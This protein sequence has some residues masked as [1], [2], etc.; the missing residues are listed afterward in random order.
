MMKTRN[1]WIRLSALLAFLIFLSACTRDPKVLAARYVEN[2]NKFFAREKYKEASIMYRRAL[3]KDLR[4]GEAYYRLGLTDEK[5]GAYGDAARMFQR[6]IE[7]QPNN[8]D[9]MTKLADIYLIAGVQGTG[10]NRDSLLKDAKDLADKLITQNQKSFDGHRILG[11]LALVRKDVPAALEEFR[12]ANQIQPDQPDV[13]ISYFRAL[14]LNK[15]FPEAEKLALDFLQ[16]NKSSASM[17]DVLYLEYVTQ[18]PPRIADAEKLLREKVEN[19]PKN[20]QYLIQLAT[21]YFVAKDRARM[22]EVMK[23]LTDEKQFPEGHLLGGDYYMFRIREFDNA[24]KEYL[25]GEKAFP[26]E[27]A[28]Y[29]KRRVELLATTAKNREANELLAQVIKDNPKDSDAIAMRAALMLSTGNRDQ[30]NQAVNDFQ[31]LV[32]KNPDN[33]LLRFNLGRALAAHGDTDAAILQLEEAAKLRPDFIPARQLLARLYLT[34]GDS[35]A[36]KTSED[37]LK[38][39][40]ADLTAHLVHANALLN[41]GEN[42]KASAELDAVNKAY[43]QSPEARYMLGYVAYA[44]KDY[45]K[46]EETFTQ[47]HKEN[48]KDIRG[49]VAVVRTLAAQHRLPDALKEMDEAYKAE[50]DRRDIKT[51]YANLLLSAEKYDDAIKLSQ[52]LV[53]KDPK[54][55]DLLFLMGEAYRRKG[56]L[57]S[58]IDY[59]RRSSVAAPND[60]AP[61]IQLALL[62]EGTGKRDQAKPIYEQILKLRPDQAIA[63]NNLAFIKAEEGTDLDQA[64]TMAQKALQQAPTSTDVADTLGWIYIKKN[65]SDEA[66]RLYKDLIN[67]DPNNAL[68][69]YHFAMALIQKGDRSQAKSELQKA[70]TLK[71]S[72]D[73]EQKIKELLQQA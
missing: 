58:A 7:F 64:L 38:T 35:K 40:P 1:L 51:A 28:L 20:G 53:D 37:I 15:Q 73:D 56:D 42:D 60:I 3:Q 71:P 66:V 21:H 17:Y 44:K 31:S 4:D 55:A 45:K 62:M 50:P 19:N 41:N 5:L 67:K 10:A 52:E 48:P 18:M 39:N 72:K 59:F 54:A 47:I 30:I 6:A 24:E 25:A 57:N 13:A 16:K 12:A 49:L 26:K 11:Q 34:K 70:L 46:A 33:H 2:G 61:L 69:H 14:T 9:A 8:A 29:Q 43:P 23:K 22:D 27:K 36:L 68:F 32:T 65:V 63:L